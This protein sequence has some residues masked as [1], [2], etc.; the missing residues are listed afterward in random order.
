MFC[1]CKI[2]NRLTYTSLN[3]Y[4]YLNYDIVDCKWNDWTI[5]TCSKTCGG[6]IRTNTRTEKVAAA[7]GGIKCNGFASIEENCNSQGCPGDIIF[8]LH[9]LLQDFYFHA[10]MLRCPFHVDFVDL[11]VHLITYLFLF[12]I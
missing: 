5:G 8:L 10:H 6:G 1:L 7:Y 12:T 4:L 3:T 9:F 11:L 2:N